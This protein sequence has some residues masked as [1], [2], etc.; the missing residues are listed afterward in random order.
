MIGFVTASTV[1]D[2]VSADKAP[3]PMPADIAN[4][5]SAVVLFAKPARARSRA[6]PRS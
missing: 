4:H 5:V 3:T 1:P 2:D 6:T